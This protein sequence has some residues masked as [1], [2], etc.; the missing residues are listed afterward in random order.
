[1]RRRLVPLL[2]LLALATLLLPTAAWATS[3]LFNYRV[4]GASSRAGPAPR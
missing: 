4:R 1:M 2:V 3:G